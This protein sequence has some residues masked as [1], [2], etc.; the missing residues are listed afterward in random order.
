MHWNNGWIRAVSNEGRTICNGVW[1]G[2]GQ[3]AGTSAGRICSLRPVLRINAEI[4]D[5]K[6]GYLELN[7]PVKKDGNRG[8]LNVGFW[9]DV[10]FEKEEK[11]TYPKEAFT[12]ENAVKIPCAQV[13][14]AY[15]VKFER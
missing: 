8:W 3:T 1:S 2:T 14:G 10:P 4:R 12:V 13:L 6:K 7:T 11:N 15:M 9:E 5:E